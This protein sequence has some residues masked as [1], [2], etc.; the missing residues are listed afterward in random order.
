MKPT[1]G[2][3]IFDAFHRS[4]T[5]LRKKHIGL[6]VKIKW[7]PGHK[8][9]EGNEMVDEQVKK[10]IMEGSSATDK[11]PKLL[12]KKLPHSKSAMIQAFGEK[13]KG[14]VQKA[15]EASKQYGKMKGTDPTTPS[16]K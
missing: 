10:V 13:L 2:H 12:K 14:R 6:K 11:L 15:W 4:I 7:V 5:E 16:N 8:G 1:T 3:Y 9:V